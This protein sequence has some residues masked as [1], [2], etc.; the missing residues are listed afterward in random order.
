M[1]AVK[2]VAKRR[3]EVGDVDKPAAGSA[4]AVIKVINCGICGSDLHYWEAG[5]G[6]GGATDLIMGHEF[7]GILEDPGS[8]RDLKKGDRVTA[9]PA[10]PCGECGPCK[11]GLLNLCVNVVKRPHPG[12]N[13]PGA[14]AEYIAVRPDMVRKLADTITD[15][16]ASMIEPSAVALHAVACASVKPGCRSLVVGAGSIGLLCAAWLRI[17]GASYIA[18]TEVNEER[19][20]IAQ[21]LGDLDEV[22]DARDEKLNSKI[23]K[24]TAGGVD[25]AI[26]ASAADA[27]INSAL[28]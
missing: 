12:L 1:K 27:G 16:S 17:S 20:A 4:N 19:R 22:F 18:M 25:V 7:G 8:S 15:L 28:L 21:K 9:V 6:M 10:N 11:N 5:A 24:A 3:L 26:D 2:L 14:Y 23:K 13:S